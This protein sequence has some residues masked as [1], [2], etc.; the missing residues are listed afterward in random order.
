VKKLVL[1]GL[2]AMTTIAYGAEQNKPDALT[3]GVSS[4]QTLSLAEGKMA[5]EDSGHGSPVLV[6]IPGLGD[7]RGQF[8]LLAPILVSYGYRVVVVDPRGQGDSDGTFA[9]FTASAIGDDVSD[10]LKSFPDGVYLVGNS[11]GGGSAA[12]IAENHPQQVKG[13]VFLDAFLRD[14][15]MGFF[16]RNFMHLALSGFWGKDMWISYYQSLFKGHPPAD[17]K[18]YCAALKDSLGLNRHM[19]AVRDMVFGSKSDIEAGLGKVHTPVLA[20][21]GSLDPDFKQPEVEVDWIVKTLGGQKL[22]IENAGHYPHLEYPEQV[23]K[24]IQN[25][26]KLQMN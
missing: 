15:P 8:R 26:I 12:W 21:A 2:M 5:Y 17:Q 23:A 25:F 22:M 20:I 13:I 19:T 1:M 9:R 24:A 6:C 14:H 11:S 3:S 4:C 7:S 10:L 16:L 18:E